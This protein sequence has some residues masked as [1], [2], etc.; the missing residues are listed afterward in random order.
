MVETS[1]NRHFRRAYKSKARRYQDDL[2]KVSQFAC[3][4]FN[5]VEKTKRWLYQATA[6]LE[7]CSPIEYILLGKGKD[8]LKLLK[9]AENEKEKSNL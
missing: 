7:E 9:R 1:E 2:V 4:F 6:E 3:K 8:V 5:D